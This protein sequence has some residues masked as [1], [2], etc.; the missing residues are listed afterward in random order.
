MCER[1]SEQAA[2]V[3]GSRIA[4]LASQRRSDDVLLLLSGIASRARAAKAIATDTDAD[5]VADTCTHGRKVQI[6][7]Q[8][9]IHMQIQIQIL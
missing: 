8:A 1:T 9:L 5:T 7:I 6:K 4:W 3:I 2:V